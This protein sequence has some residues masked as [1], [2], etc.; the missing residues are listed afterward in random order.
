MV[1]ADD[2]HVLAGTRSPGGLARRLRIK[3]AT[4]RRDWHECGQAPPK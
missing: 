4:V 3:K 2:V 1:F